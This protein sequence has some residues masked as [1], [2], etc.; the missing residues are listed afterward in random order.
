MDYK[1]NIPGRSAMPSTGN[2][3]TNHT[4][5]HSTANSS[6]P[7]NSSIDS[8]SSSYAKS[9][10]PSL[11]N[12]EVDTEPVETKKAINFLSIHPLNVKQIQDTLAYVPKL[13]KFISAP[14]YLLL[15][16][17]LLENLI[18]HENEII[19][20]AIIT[21]MEN[22]ERH[23]N[24]RPDQKYLFS[25]AKNNYNKLVE[26]IQSERDYLVSKYTQSPEVNKMLV[27]KIYDKFMNQKTYVEA[28]TVT[29]RGILL[30]YI[31]QRYKLAYSE[32]FLNQVKTEPFLL[33]NKYLPEACQMF[34]TIFSYKI[35]LIEVNFQTTG[36]ERV[37]RFEI[38]PNPSSKEY[39]FSTVI[40]NVVEKTR[41]YKALGYPVEMPKKIDG[42][43]QMVMEP[44]S[45]SKKSDS[46]FMQ[47][48]SPNKMAIEDNR[49]EE[50]KHPGPEIPGRSKNLASHSMETAG[51]EVCNVCSVPVDKLDV[52]TNKYC[53]HR[54]CVY[55]LKD[56]ELRYTS[57]C[58][59][60]VC[61][62]KMDAGSLLAF[63]RNYE[64]RAQKEQLNRSTAPS[65]SKMMSEQD[66][67]NKQLLEEC[68]AC[69][70]MK[71][72]KNYF[73][74]SCGHR[75]CLDCIQ[76]RIDFT[77][78]FCAER[79]CPKKLDS[80]VLRRFMGKDM[81]IETVSLKL[82]CGRCRKENDVVM[83]GTGTVKPDYVKCVKCGSL[84]C[85][86]HGDLI[87]K[88]LCFCD[89][90]LKLLELNIKTMVKACNRCRKQ[91]C[92]VCGEKKAG[93]QTCD[94]IC[95]LCLDKKSHRRNKLCDSCSKGQTQ[96]PFCLDQLDEQNEYVQ[97]C[98]HKICINC[99]WDICEEFLSKKP[100]SGPSCPVCVRLVSKRQI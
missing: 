92:A 85:V 87:E 10:K 100:G 21:E 61:R 58:F 42:S 53:G 43:N 88:C 57:E 70:K 23:P 28:I 31:I 79:N 83:Q 4:T 44:E 54:I 52:F 59:M 3:L 60:R 17:I 56:S 7:S 1:Y 29:F 82:V 5:V 81:D 12:A 33:D 27:K 41:R 72:N 22:L 11:L 45:K 69:G 84:S 76:K 66:S 63:V 94:C 68:D 9:T 91:F 67:G 96:C 39:V 46:S 95:E 90:C 18:E 19:Y 62:S 25:E 14:T 2:S 55:C 73:T 98:G 89:T 16:C 48:E 49:M 47:T 20:T 37:D 71:N 36:K 93:F 8:K 13:R 32:E 97:T 30:S 65:D 86:K 51:T 50:I 26:H 78:R 77:S 64:E 75:Y 74:N 24:I 6:R 15:G 40:F 34:S 80:E 99:R 38:Y 35:D